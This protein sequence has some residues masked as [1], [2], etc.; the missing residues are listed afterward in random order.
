M[1]EDT[2]PP[3]TPPHRSIELRDSTEEESWLLVYLDV[4]TLLVVMFVVML[5]FAGD[6]DPE[7]AADTT[8]PAPETVGPSPHPADWPEGSLGDDIEISRSDEGLRLRISSGLLFES[9]RAELSQKGLDT[10]AELVPTLQRSSHP[11]VVTGH[12]DDVPITTDRYPSNWEL[13]SARAAQVV[14]FFQKEG[15]TPERMSAVGKAHTQPRTSNESAEG[16]ARNRR[17]ELLL[18]LQSNEGPRVRLLPVD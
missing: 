13:S 7:T 5:T 16:R 6:S 2:T 17:V 9:G 14:R 11:I 10:L 8:E 12:T 18:R 4:M 15:I 3:R 1:S